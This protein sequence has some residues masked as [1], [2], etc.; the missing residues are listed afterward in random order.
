MHQGRRSV[1]NDILLDRAYQETR[2]AICGCLTLSVLA[3]ISLL[4]IPVRSA[5]VKLREQ[6]LA[7]WNDYVGWVR[8]HT[9]IRLKQSPFLWISEL[10]P[11]RAEV[12]SG[13]IPVWRQG[14]E[15][16]RRCPTDF[17]HDWPGAVF[18]PKG[19]ISKFWPSR[20]TMTAIQKSISLLSLRRNSFDRQD[21]M[22]CFP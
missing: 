16:P 10:P 7:A 12:R 8:L 15:H 21:L 9:K 14:T 20:A 1:Q 4:S 13:D 18:I 3:A 2:K 11:R 6:T 5:P 19:T 17:I 22:T